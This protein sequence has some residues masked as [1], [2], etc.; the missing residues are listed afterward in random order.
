MEKNGHLPRRK[1][2]QAVAKVL[3]VKPNEIVTDSLAGAAR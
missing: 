3:R 1:T 2:V